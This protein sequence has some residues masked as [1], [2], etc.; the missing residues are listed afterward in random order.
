M[1]IT[2]RVALVGSALAIASAL[3]TARADG[4]ASP[5][6][7]GLVDLENTVQIASGFSPD[8]LA[9]TV[10]FRNMDAAASRSSG[11]AVDSR[12]QTIK[13]PID[14][15][16]KGIRLTQ[17]VRGFVSRKGKAKATLVV[18][19][20]GKT[21]VVDLDK[22]KSPAGAT[23]KPANASKAVADSRKSAN[24]AAANLPAS[25]ATPDGSF[26]FMTRIEANVPAGATYQITLM[27]LVERQGE[28]ADS[29]ALL[30]VDSLDVE[31]RPSAK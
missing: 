1:H 15:N 5:T 21:T 11:N 7:H 26:D 30:V 6:F 29:E 23:S 28:A 9:T 14:K 2:S 8:K 24:D 17:D 3:G 19:A 12:I 13:I 25:A 27:L 10:I 20:A 22:A 31:L 16:E 4:P 18:Q